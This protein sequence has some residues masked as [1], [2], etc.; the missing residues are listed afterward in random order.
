MSSNKLDI[1]ADQ[2]FATQRA[3]L[4]GVV[5]LLSGQLKGRGATPDTD[6]YWSTRG[7]TALGQSFSKM[8]LA[9]RSVSRS[10]PFTRGDRASSPVVSIPVTNLPIRGDIYV[11]ESVVDDNFGWENTKAT[12]R[13]GYL[14]PG[15][16]MSD[17]ADADWTSLVLDGFFGAPQELNS[18]GLNVVLY[19]RGAKRNQV[20]RQRVVGAHS[21]TSLSS[22]GLDKRD[23]GTPFPIVVGRPDTWFRPPTTQTQVRGFTVS[24]YSAGDTAIQIHPLTSGFSMMK[25]GGA[26]NVTRVMVHNRTPLYQTTTDF[27]D[28]VFD[29]VNNLLTFEL[30]SGLSNDVPR[31]AYVQ[32]FGGVNGFQWALA[33]Y[34]LLSTPD[35]GGSVGFRFGDGRVVTADPVR[36]PFEISVLNGGGDHISE[37]GNRETFLKLPK[38]STSNPNIPVFFDPNDPNSVAVTEQPVFG[39]TNKERMT[40]KI[41][42]GTGGTGANNAN[43]RDGNANTA[44]LVNPAN[45]ITITFNSP[46]APFANDDT[47]TS[48]LHFIC[49]T[50]VVDFK[51]ST[52]SITFGSSTGA[53]GTYRFTQPTPR[54]FNETI[55]MSAAGAGN[56]QEVWWEH[57]LEADITLT[58]D[59]DVS[60]GTGVSGEVGEVMQYAE[61]VFR[62][63]PDMRG[64]HLLEQVVDADGS[65]IVSPWRDTETARGATQQPI[66][67]PAAVLA[68]LQSHLLGIDGRLNTIN[69]ASYDSADQRH[70]DEG[71]RWNFVLLE[72]IKSWSELEAMLA[73]Q[74]RTDFYYGPSGH[75]MVFREPLSIVEAETVLQ[76]FVLPGLPG[77]NTFTGS[78]PTIERTPVSDIIN[79]VMVDYSPDYSLSR[80]S[81]TWQGT[82]EVADD[83]SVT[84][85]GEQVD[86]QGRFGFWAHSADPGNSKYDV[87]TSV[88]GIARSIAERHAFSNLR[89]SFGTAWVAHGLDRGSIVTVDFLAAKNSPRRA[90]CEV[91]QIFTHPQN[92]ERVDLVCRAVAPIEDISEAFV[93]TDRFDLAET[94]VDE[95]G[96]GQRW[97]DRFDEP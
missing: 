54:D 38:G 94:W 43:A 90:R 71:I 64:T 84:L 70:E 59:T 19:N 42:Y 27:A 41:N 3:N 72:P 10:A 74:T 92:D 50:G 68:G 16:V 21:P 24:G 65:D 23:V 86:P 77:A 55:R 85:F 88:S 58:R 87:N 13:V 53:A 31:G 73:D 2:G 45:V 82:I 47:T 17:L 30:L 32:E 26:I 35:L 33:E 51:D 93:W 1:T 6:F 89:F 4:N 52:G 34:K 15:Q 91:E 22:T 62:M 81:P 44:V 29:E 40:S 60:V 80:T 61:V 8:I 69:Q 76:A 66:S 7:G 39:T 78:G 48:T 9:P 36:W 57:D 97:L 46:P 96:V 95:F 5:Y 11:V 20:V 49:D 12:L 83:D 28:V 25:S 79:T 63:P 14:K 37:L 75:E 56:V 67:R 18:D